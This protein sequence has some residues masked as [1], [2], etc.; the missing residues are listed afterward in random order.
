MEFWFLAP[1]GA[2]NIVAWCLLIWNDAKITRSNEVPYFMSATILSFSSIVFFFIALAKLGLSS[3]ERNAS[4]D[5]YAY[6]SGI[7]AIVSTTL[8][9]RPFVYEFRHRRDSIAPPE[10]ILKFRFRRQDDPSDDP[11]KAA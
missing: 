8:L 3:W 10:N 5:N 2:V 9:L 6:A 1:V 11:P 4:I 7:A